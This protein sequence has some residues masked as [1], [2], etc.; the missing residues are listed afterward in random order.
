[1]ANVGTAQFGLIQPSMSRAWVWAS[2]S[3]GNRLPQPVDDGLD[4]RL[5]KT[6]ERA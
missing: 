1:M 4:G 6:Y 2:I 5:R 3:R